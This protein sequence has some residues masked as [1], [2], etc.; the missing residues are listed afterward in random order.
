M[1]NHLLIICSRHTYSNCLQVRL[2]MR[3]QGFLQ[4]HG[5]NYNEREG[6]SGRAVLRQ[7]WDKVCEPILLASE[8]STLTVKLQSRAC[9]QKHLYHLTEHS[10]HV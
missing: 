4:T 9:Q 3:V 1:T 10:C 8:K 2:F 7:C 5:T 6:N